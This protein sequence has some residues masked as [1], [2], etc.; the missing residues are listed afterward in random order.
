M[1]IAIREKLRWSGCLVNKYKPSSS[2]DVISSSLFFDR[3]LKT[4]GWGVFDGL[5]FALFTRLL[6]PCLRWSN[7]FEGGKT[8]RKCIQLATGVSSG[9]LITARQTFDTSSVAVVVTI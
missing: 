2:G 8:L 4:S 1:G 3:L 6:R 5:I 7:V 9:K